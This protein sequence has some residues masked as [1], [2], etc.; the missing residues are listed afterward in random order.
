M[1]SQQPQLRPRPVGNSVR[2]K[3]Y[4]RRHTPRVRLSSSPSQQWRS[5][6]SARKALCGLAHLRVQRDLGDGAFGTAFSAK[7][8]AGKRVV[9]KVNHPPKTLDYFTVEY[10]KGEILALKLPPHPHVMKTH[11]VL[12]GEREKDTYHLVKKPS[13]LSGRN[14]ATL[15]VAGAICEPAYGD[16]LHLITQGKSL[17]SQDIKT[18][19]QQIT[20]ILLHLHRQG[21][22]HR[23]ISLSNI[24]YSPRHGIKL[25][26]MGTLIQTLD[27][28]DSPV[29]TYQYL[30]PD[31]GEPK[32]RQGKAYS[33]AA[34]DIW[35]AGC[36]LFSCLTGGAVYG[37]NS[38]TKMF[39]SNEN[40]SANNASDFARLSNRERKK[41]LLANLQE[42]AK[43][44]P[45]EYINLVVEMLRY[46]PAKRPSAQQVLER[47][48]ACTA[49]TKI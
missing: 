21:F 37:Y 26:D 35:E 44:L 15:Y 19:F 38:Q 33:P 45:P 6:R 23:D 16:T 46:D 3:L 34:L 20:E 11:S 36:S 47:L 41:I 49:E 27:Q 25:I 5:F 39:D 2:G 17:T 48:T 18:I 13:Q 1:I 22:Y 29:G 32:H 43:S 14:W 31:G 42:P 12:V 8:P 10:D 9:A 40:N 7:T 4:E 30:K 28:P 24:S